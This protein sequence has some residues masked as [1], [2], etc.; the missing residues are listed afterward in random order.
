MATR[1]SGEAGALC[2]RIGVKRR[3]AIKQGLRAKEVRE[4][5]AALRWGVP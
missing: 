2:V 3:M 4:C 5:E 1:G